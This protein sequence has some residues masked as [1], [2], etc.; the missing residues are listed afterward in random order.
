MTATP[1]G[2]QAACTKLC[3]ADASQRI[4]AML[5]AVRACRCVVLLL[6]VLVF[7]SRLS[8]RIGG[9]Q[10]EGCMGEHGGRLQDCARLCAL[11]RGPCSICKAP[12]PAVVS[13]PSRA[14]LPAPLQQCGVQ[15]TVVWGCWVPGIDFVCCGSSTAS[16]LR[17]WL[18]WPPGWRGIQMQAAKGRCSVPG[19]APVTTQCGCPAQSVGRL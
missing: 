16:W 8:G 5:R 9:A 11:H 19:S 10:L 17:I 3:W 13:T 2:S 6:A 14:V 12:M 4:V 18:C 15:C 1:L 7:P